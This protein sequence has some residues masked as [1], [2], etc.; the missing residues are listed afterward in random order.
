M[1]QLPLMIGFGASSNKGKNEISDI[2]SAAIEQQI[3]AFD[4]APSYCTEEIL[5]EVIAEKVR[6]G[7]I[8]REEIFL[9][10]K[11]DIPQMVEGKIQKH[12]EMTLDEMKLKYI[13]SILI[14]WPLPDLL[15]DTF[16]QLQK[17]KGKGL[18]KYIGICNL[19]PRLL[20]DYFKHDI[21][22]DIIQIERNPLRICDKELEFC[23]QNGIILQAYSPLCKMNPEL[24]ENITLKKISYKYGKSIG[25]I[26]LRWHIQTNVYPVFATK[27]TERIKEYSHIMDFK[28]T[29]EEIL[30]ISK[31]DK[32]YKRYLESWLCPGY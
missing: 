14:H 9:Q 28:L 1:K 5:G 25:Q 3:K 30:Q 10:T 8:T 6:A 2:V 23:L 13:D 16:V 18:V 29:D 7:I 20:S 19:N 21:I 4:T 12:V 17:I 27:K 24:L 11:I 32:G 31:L 26:I 22:P 15:S